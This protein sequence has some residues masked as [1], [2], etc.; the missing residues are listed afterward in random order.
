MFV[1]ASLHWIPVGAD[2][3]AVLAIHGDIKPSNVLVFHEDGQLV[4]KL[5]DF[6]YSS[7]L[8]EG[9]EFMINIPKSRP[10]CAPELEERTQPFTIPEAKK[11]DI[12]SLGLLAL[13]L[14]FGSDLVSNVGSQPDDDS[15]SL[16]ANIESY[17]ERQEQWAKF[18]ESRKKNNELVQ[19]A[20]EM[21]DQDGMFADHEKECWRDFFKKT[22]SF[23][24]H[25][26]A[27]EVSELLTILDSV[28]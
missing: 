9:F 21:L 27:C 15:M 11:T 24:P 4:V 16:D 5:S 13:W 18:I 23:E 22:L 2:F 25:L 3:A 10:W 17:Y 12:F 26:R 7:I 8:G 28:M 14:F 20:L 6:G 19:L 1:P